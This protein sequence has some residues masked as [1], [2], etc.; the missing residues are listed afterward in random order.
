LSHEHKKSGLCCDGRNG[1]NFVLFY[2]LGDDSLTNHLGGFEMTVKAKFAAAP[3]QG[4][5]RRFS[6]FSRGSKHKSYV[7]KYKTSWRKIWMW[8]EGKT[9]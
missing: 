8:V 9:F 2:F 7:D 3:Y 1:P 5:V 4:F 6:S